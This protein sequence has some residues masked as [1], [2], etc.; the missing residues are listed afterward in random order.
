MMWPDTGLV[1]VA[2]CC[3]TVASSPF[4]DTGHTPVPDHLQWKFPAW[5]ELAP[6]TLM[7][8]PLSFK[9]SLTGHI[10]SRAH[11]DHPKTIAIFPLPI[12]ILWATC[13]KS[14]NQLLI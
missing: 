7:G 14:L 10:A 5:E 9:S 4:L 2:L 6:D 13:L 1:S 8:I 11:T 3:S 12:L